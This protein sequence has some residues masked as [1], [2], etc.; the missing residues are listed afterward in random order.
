M[1]AVAFLIR[2]LGGLAVGIFFY[3]GLWFTVNRLATSRYRALLLIGSFG[4]RTLVVLSGFL[5]LIERRWDYA[6]LCLIGFT[7]GRLVV[8]KFMVGRRVRA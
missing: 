2:L 6:L 5:L 7:M 8:M 3:G 4:I 1:N